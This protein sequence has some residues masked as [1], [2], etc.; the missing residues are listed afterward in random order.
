VADSNNGSIL[1]GSVTAVAYVVAAFE[2][3]ALE[4]VKFVISVALNI[5]LLNASLE[6]VKPVI[7]NILAAVDGDAGS[8]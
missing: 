7:F 5:V 4:F 8:S 2:I 1:V 3:V 6:F